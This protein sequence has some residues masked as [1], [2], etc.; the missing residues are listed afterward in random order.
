MGHAMKLWVFTEA[1]NCHCYS[2]LVVDLDNLSRQVTVSK[3]SGQVIEVSN[4]H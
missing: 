2:L 3:L 1:E 4:Q